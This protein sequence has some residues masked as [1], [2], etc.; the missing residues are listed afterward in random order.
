MNMAS[1]LRKVSFKIF[2]WRL[3]Q[4]CGFSALAG[5]RCSSADLIRDLY[6][7]YNHFVGDDGRDGKDGR[8][9]VG[10]PLLC[11]IPKHK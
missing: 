2:L 11:C 1:L 6:D 8:D 4:T 10:S 9:N 7:E 3:M 5:Q